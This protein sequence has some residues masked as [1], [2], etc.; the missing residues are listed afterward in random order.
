MFSHIFFSNISFRYY[1]PALVFTPK[2]TNTTSSF[3][4]SIQDLLSSPMDSK[5]RGYK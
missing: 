1:H 2:A 4:E 3:G 5:V